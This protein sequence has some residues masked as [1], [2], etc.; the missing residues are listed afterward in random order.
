MH[1]QEVFV[2]NDF[3]RGEEIQDLSVVAGKKLVL[4]PL[5][6]PLVLFLS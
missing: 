1:S 2:R 5:D 4:H 3:Y 6:D